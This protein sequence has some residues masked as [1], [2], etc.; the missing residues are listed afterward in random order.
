[1]PLENKIHIFAPPCNILYIRTLEPPGKDPAPRILREAYSTRSRL[2][3]FFC[4]F[5]AILWEPCSQKLRFFL[6]R[7]SFPPYAR[8][9]LGCLLGFWPSG[10]ELFP[11]YILP[12]C[13]VYRHVNYCSSHNVAL[14]FSLNN[15]F[16]KRKRF[17]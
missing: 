10:L 9:L 13:N 5:S 4:V 6:L 14:R 16:R 8:E 12:L 2:S 11:S 1:M 3:Q 7:C 17:L 15:T